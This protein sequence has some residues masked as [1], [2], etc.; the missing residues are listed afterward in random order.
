MGEIRDREFFTCCSEVLARKLLGKIICHRVVEKG[1]AFVIKLRIMAT[2]AYTKCDPFTDANRSKKKNS[3]FLEGGH[4]Y[5]CYGGEGYN[6]MDIVADKEGIPESVLIAVTD[7]YDGPQLTLWA[8]D[9]DKRKFDGADLVKC[10]EIWLED[11]GAVVEMA[12]IEKRRNIKNEALLRF[13]VERIRF[14]M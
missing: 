6:R 5:F 11:D 3:Q 13:S 14:N 9:A 7:M 2:E 4:L 10:K 8:L 12:R 1:E